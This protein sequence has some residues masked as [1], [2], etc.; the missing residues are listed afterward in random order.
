[1]ITLQ[2]WALPFYTESIIN[3]TCILAN[4][5]ILEVCIILN[6]LS[7][8]R[9]IKRTLL[10]Q[11]L[12]VA[13]H[14]HARCRFIISFQY[15]ARGLLGSLE[16]ISV[17]LICLGT[18]FLFACFSFTMDFMMSR[19]LPTG[20]AGCFLYVLLKCFK[21]YC[22]NLARDIQRIVNLDRG[23]PPKR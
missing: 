13:F 2:S 15:S 10:S 20:N 7:S 14:M 11:I 23:P 12:R 21:G 1:M 16:V 18:I 8:V 6:W 19:F 17:G 4:K 5:I 9:M 3:Y 22:L